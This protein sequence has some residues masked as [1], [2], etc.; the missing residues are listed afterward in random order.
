MKIVLIGLILA[1]ASMAR[2]GTSEELS[3]LGRTAF[4]KMHYAQAAAVLSRIPRVQRSVSDEAF[5]AWS[6]YYLGNSISAL[7]GFRRILDRR[8]ASVDALCG[9]GWSLYTL[10]R[11]PAGAEAFRKALRLAPWHASSIEGLNA[12]NAHRASKQAT[13]PIQPDRPFGVANYSLTFLSYT[14]DT[15]RE[16]GWVHDLLLSGGRVGKGYLNLMLTYSDINSV[17]GVAA[18]Q[19][20]EVRPSA[21]FY[22]G[23]LVWRGS[24]AWLLYDD[25]TVEDQSIWQVGLGLETLNWK[26]NPFVDA[27]FLDASDTTLYQAVPGLAYGFAGLKLRS[28][29]EVGQY[30]F[31]ALD[32]MLGLYFEQSLFW[33][34]TAESFIHLGGGAGESYYGYRSPG[35][36]FYSLPD[37]RLADAWLQCGFDF[38]PWNIALG[39]SY[40]RFEGDTGNQYNSLGLTLSCG[41]F[42]DSVWR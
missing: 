27:Y 3:I 31:Q 8:P 13:P 32:D 15:P 14:G 41:L 1:L 40:A 6:N 28:A 20:T 24:G 9:V 23:G 11:Y 39:V 35:G 22:A 10:Q 19:Q 18:L 34:P 4:E 26:V 25:N 29:L 37:K 16:D 7:D 33:R 12:C 42:W 38:N 30:N 21:G 17:E 5:L 36:V 2:A